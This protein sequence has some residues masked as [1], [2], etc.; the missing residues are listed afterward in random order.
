[1]ELWILGFMGL[2]SKGFRRD[3]VIFR[4]KVKAIVMVDVTSVRCVVRFQLYNSS[5]HAYKMGSL[6][7][8]AHITF[9]AEGL[10]EGY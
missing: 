9:T 8:N 4:E 6:L 2:R 5:L 10:E 3:Q 1:M 7:S